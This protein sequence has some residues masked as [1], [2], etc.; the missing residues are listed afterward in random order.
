M[1]IYDLKPRF[2]AILRP[3]CVQL[4]SRGVSPNQV[5]V[6]ALVLSAA[7]GLWIYLYPTSAYPFLWLP[8]ALFLRMGLNAIDGM[9]A[10]EHNQQ[11]PEGALLNELGDILSDLFLYLPF[12]IVPGFTPELVILVVI[13]SGLSE[14]AGIA[15]IQIGA[16]RNYRGPMG[17]SDRAFVFGLVS[18][19]I[20]IGFDLEGWLPWIL[21]LM[22]LL[23][24]LT[25]WNRCRAALQ[26]I[27]S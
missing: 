12:A 23:L 10:R 9:L 20:G 16:S 7:S 18:F 17:K 4:A 3:L 14:T 1:S 2:Q 25:I 11:S 5:T 24:I 21:G 6:F 22:I 8:L 13:F 27:R 15:A 19:L 26:E